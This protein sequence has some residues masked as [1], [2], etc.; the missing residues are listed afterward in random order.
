MVLRAIFLSNKF[1][2]KKYPFI[3]HIYMQT[4]SSHNIQ[5]FYTVIKCL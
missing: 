3:C 5:T 4:V 1:L 2:S